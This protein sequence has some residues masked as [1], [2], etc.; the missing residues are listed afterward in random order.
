VDLKEL[1]NR[2][3]ADLLSLRHPWETSR[4]H[5]FEHLVKSRFKDKAIRAMDM[6]SGDT[7]LA[8]RLLGHLPFGSSMDCIDLSYTPE[9]RQ[10]FTNPAAKVRALNEV[11]AGTKYDLMTLLDVVEHVE[12]DAG[13]LSGLAEKHLDPDG[14]III[15]V[16]AYQTLFSSHDVWLE[17]CRRY[18]PSAG[19]NLIKQCGLEIVE[20][21]GLFHSLLYARILSKLK[22]KLFSSVPQ[23]GVS[24]WQGGPGMTGF[25]QGVLDTDWHVTEAL[26]KVGMRLPG[27][28]WWCVCRKR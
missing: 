19:R 16:P 9:Q 5:F 8:K 21:G 15:S 10:Q 26:R 28:S 23:H 25:I 20:D 22:E 1:S 3:E 12:G 6:G 24:Q 13:F 11:P 4:A 7:W 17:H 18:S 27:L 2:G 14:W